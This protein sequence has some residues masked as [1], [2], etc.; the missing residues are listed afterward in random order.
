MLSSLTSCEEGAWQGG[1]AGVSQH[2]ARGCL[3]GLRTGRGAAGRVYPPPRQATGV[4]PHPGRCPWLPPRPQLLLPGLGYHGRPR[5]LTGLRGAARRLRRLPP[6]RGFVPGESPGSGAG[7]PARAALTLSRPRRSRGCC[8]GLR[9]HCRPRLLPGRRSA[10]PGS[11]RPRPPPPPWVKEAPGRG[12]CGC[13]QRRGG[14]A[15]PPGPAAAIPGTGAR[16]TVEVP[17]EPS[18]PGRCH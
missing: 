12:S 3:T 15:R 11:P 17:V 10:S 18:P 6:G 1:A 4:S 13:P 7:D 5:R 9:L 16:F 14:D 8:S 2:R